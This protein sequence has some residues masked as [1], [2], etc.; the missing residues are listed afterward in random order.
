MIF[1]SSWGGVGGARR[2]T[3]YVDDGS[4][5][6][7][8]PHENA[9]ADARASGERASLRSRSSEPAGRSTLKVEPAPFPRL[10][11]NPS[12][13]Q[14][15]ELA[16]DVEA[17]ARPAHAARQLGVEAIELLED[18]GCSAGGMPSPSSLTANL[19]NGSRL[20]TASRH[21]AAVRAS[22]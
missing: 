2:R 13:H 7:L 22:T 11:A 10:D 15:H 12:V 17:E 14:A 8:R 4:A 19:T 3:T 9:T 18:P 16:G 5:R 1:W 20:V 21:G 6:V